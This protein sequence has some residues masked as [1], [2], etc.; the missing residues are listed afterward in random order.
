MEEIE[1]KINAYVKKKD[2]HY[3]QLFYLSHILYGTI[4]YI[5]FTI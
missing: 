2:F 3:F 4:I 5:I 1:K